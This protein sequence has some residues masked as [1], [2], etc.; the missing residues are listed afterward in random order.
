[1]A[2]KDYTPFVR[3]NYFAPFGCYLYFLA[4]YVYNIPGIMLVVY[5]LGIVV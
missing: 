3:K 5:V 1:M 4:M 2:Q